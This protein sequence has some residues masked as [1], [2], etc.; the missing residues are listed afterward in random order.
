MTGRVRC[1]VGENEFDLQQQH[2]GVNSSASRVVTDAVWSRQ[3]FYA[4]CARSI[5]RCTHRSVLTLTSHWLQLQRHRQVSPS[6]AFSSKSQPQT[7]TNVMKTLVYQ[8]GNMVNKWCAASLSFPPP[9]TSSRFQ[10]HLSPS[11]EPKHSFTHR[12]A[13]LF[14]LPVN[15]PVFFLFFFFFRYVEHDVVKFIREPHK[16]SALSSIRTQS[17]DIKWQTTPLW[18]KSTSKLF[19]W[20]HARCRKLKHRGDVLPLIWQIVIIQT[21]PDW[22]WTENMMDWENLEWR[23]AIFQT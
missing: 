20:R 17:E 15:V 10:H 18:T 4:T 7:A 11:H 9:H 16:H 3:A 5:D 14:L 21:F 13:S 22:S 23:R 19:L 6:L 12:A 2:V 8:A 1:D